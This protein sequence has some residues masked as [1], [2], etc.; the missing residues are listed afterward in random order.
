MRKCD[1]GV[2]RAPPQPASRSAWRKVQQE[3]EAG[4]SMHLGQ[5][6][7]IEKR[8]T[9]TDSHIDWALSSWMSQQHLRGSVCWEGEKLR[10]HAH[11]ARIW[12]PWI[13]FHA[14][15]SSDPEGVEAAHTWAQP[16]SSSRTN[17]ASGGLL[18]RHAERAA[19]GAF[20]SDRPVHDP[21][22]DR[23]LDRGCR[24]ASV[25]HMKMLGDVSVQRRG[26]QNREWERRTI[27][28]SGTLFF[29]SL[30]RTLADSALLRRAKPTGVRF[31]LPEQSCGA[32]DGSHL[33]PPVFANQDSIH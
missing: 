20:C 3:K 2:G 7:S 26:W 17:L 14:S 27:L 12:S 4:Q 21:A 15:G 28:C 25:K 24:V 23:D 8:S 16:T 29:F 30:D 5:I 31:Q 32:T 33:S 11:G 18:A 22:K 19:N 9:R 1:S 10:L 6:N 13:Q